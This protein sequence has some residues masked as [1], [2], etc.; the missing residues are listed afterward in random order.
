MFN[1]ILV[2]NR[3]EIAVRVIQT[4]KQ[5][6]YNTVAVYSEADQNSRAVQ[7]ADKAICIGPAQ[8]SESYLCIDKIIAAAKQTG[9]DAIHPGYGFLSENADF[10]QACIDAN[11]TFIGP[12][13]HAINLMG[14]KRQAKIAMEKAG[15]PCIPGY[16]DEDQSDDVLKQQ[17]EAIGFPVMIKAAA[18]GGG[19]GMRLVDENSELTVE[20]QSARSEAE[21][22]FGNGELILEKAIINPRHIEIQ[23][24]GDQQGNFVYLWERDC[25]VQRRHQKVIEEAPSPAVNAELRTAMGEAAITAAKSCDYV[26][27][28]TI[29]FLLADNGE[30]Y[31]LEMNTR[32]QVEHPV[33]ELISLQDLVAWQIHVAEGKPL[34][35]QQSEIPLQGHAIEVRLYAEDPEQ[36]FL[37]QTGMIE[38]WQ[39]SELA[40]IDHT[41]INGM[42]V[43]PHYD[44]MLAKIITHGPDRETAVRKLIRALEDTQLLGIKTNQHYLHTLLK[45][46]EFI[47]GNATTG[48]IKDYEASLKVDTDSELTAAIAIAAASRIIHTNQTRETFVGLQTGVEIP[49]TTRW[50]FGED[51]WTCQLSQVRQKGNILTAQSVI[52]NGENSVKEAT[53]KI[54]FSK[55]NA[56]LNGSIQC[57]GQE[58]PFTHASKNDHHH[59]SVKS[60]TCS[61]QCQTLTEQ[62]NADKAGSGLLK[63]PMDGAIVKVLVEANAQVEK[64][65]T[66]MLLE[67]MK[68]EHQIKADL[69]GSVTQL[70]VN[71]GDQVKNKQLLIELTGAEATS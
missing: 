59:I 22:A 47:S 49:Q 42:E 5:L 1:T 58:F 24:F 25:S 66:L 20:I 16:Q 4:A 45:H 43:S 57:D 64:G 2:A 68:M 6:G 34:P 11:I 62:S 41:I 3:G 9:A 36:Q 63:A 46:P 18:G 10:A 33:T 70:L 44:P 12:S 17:I 38:H 52:S 31:F 60:F 28:G 14:N 27:A 37:P 29:E 32:L 19:R 8:V 61:L 26:G 71:A 21:N 69:D 50:H 51:P 7:L 13:A 30:F 53:L 15:V 56:V 55:D 39:P 23:I 40:R 48:F 67:A 54:A 65:Q 35:L